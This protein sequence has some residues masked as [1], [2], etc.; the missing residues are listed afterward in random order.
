MFVVHFLET[1][2]LLDANPIKMKG[3]LSSKA[4]GGFAGYYQSTIYKMKNT[5]YRSIEQL[6]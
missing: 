5:V 1:F 6:F 3:R 4:D 2:G